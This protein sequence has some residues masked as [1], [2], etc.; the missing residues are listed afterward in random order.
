MISFGSVYKARWRGT[1]VAVKMLPSHN[2]SKEMIKNFR[3]E[4]RI[5]PPQHLSQQRS[6]AMQIHVMMALRHPNVVLFMAASTRA[7][8]MCLVMEFMALGSLFDVLHNEL[9]PEVVGFAPFPIP[10]VP[11]PLPP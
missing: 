7:E 9:I 6:N 3:D 10:V 8:R 4:V 5:I 11:D 1:D 2:P